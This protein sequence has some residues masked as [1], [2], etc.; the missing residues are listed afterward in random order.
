LALGPI[1]GGAADTD[2]PCDLL[3]ASPDVG[4]QQYLRSLQPPRC[5]LASA[6]HPDQLG[7]LGRAKL[8]AITNIHPGLLV[9]GGPLESN[10][11]T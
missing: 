9:I 10:Y 7:A 6:Q 2:R 11:A 3:V 5:V 8:N 4:R 1:D